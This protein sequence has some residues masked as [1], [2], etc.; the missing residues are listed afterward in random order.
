MDGYRDDAGMSW[1]VE[2]IEL[3]ARGLGSGGWYWTNLRNGI[4]K[5]DVRLDD[6]IESRGLVTVRMKILI[7]MI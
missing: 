7:W 3:E 4:A 2:L 5:V 6:V 1:L